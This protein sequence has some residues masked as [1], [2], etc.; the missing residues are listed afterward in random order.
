VLLAN[1]AVFVAWQ[2]P[3]LQPAMYRHFTC[4]LLNV[5]R[6]GRYYT[7]ITAAFSHATFMH[8]AFNML[9]FYTISSSLLIPHRALYGR[10]LLSEGEFL[11]LYFT[12]AIASQLIGWVL[13][14][15]FTRG[16]LRIKNMSIPGLGASGVVCSVFAISASLFPTSQYYVFLIP[17]PIYASTLLPALAAFDFIGMIFSIYRFSP[18]AHHVHLGGIIYGLL[19]CYGYIKPKIRQRLVEDTKK[20]Q[21]GTLQD[22]RRWW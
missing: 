4:S 22:G 13:Q 10:S 6:E 21:E 7:L 15:I 5:F 3:P 16:H 1:T 9:A 19:V 20:A 11:S 12:A 8:F 18:L 17:Y 14:L 2:L